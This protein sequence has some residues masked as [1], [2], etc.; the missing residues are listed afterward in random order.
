MR[1]DVA[2]YSD[3]VLALAL[4]AVARDVLAMM[5]S[6]GGNY[7]PVMSQS[8]WDATE[9]IT[10]DAMQRFDRLPD[11]PT[12][13]LIE[14]LAS[15][16]WCVIH[17]NWASHPGELARWPLAYGR[18]LAADVAMTEAMARALPEPV[19]D[20]LADYPADVAG[21]YVWHRDRAPEP[22]DSI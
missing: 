2:R 9:V 14:E 17:K 21:G 16:T 13:L 22:V 20:P 12:D 1:R 3:S 6:Y 4:R 5:V 15:A 18:L 7:L 11:S 10:G 19:R 8:R